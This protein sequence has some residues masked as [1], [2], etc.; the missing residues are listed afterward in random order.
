MFEI[1]RVLNSPKE[2]SEVL[3]NIMNLVRPMV[4]FDQCC[5]WEAEPSNNTI[6]R[7]IAN[8]PESQKPPTFTVGDG[9]LRGQAYLSRT[10]LHIP[11]L[12]LASRRS[13]VEPES[14][15]IVIIPLIFENEVV[16]LI[17]FY[18]AYPNYYD[19]RNLPT[20]QAIADEIAISVAKDRLFREVQ[21][22]AVT[23]KLTGLHNRLYFEDRIA[24]DINR[25]QRYGH[26]VSLLFIDID[27]FKICNDTYGHAAGDS[28]LRELSSVLRSSV[29]RTDLVARYG[30]EEFVMILPNTAKEQ[31]GILAEKIRQVVSTYEFTHESIKITI[32]VSIGVASYP[33][34][35]ND[36]VGL[37][38]KADYAMYQA[39]KLG[40][41]RV[42]HS[43]ASNNVMIS[44]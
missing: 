19:K 28:V 9:G 13:A 29:R 15:S 2:F 39:K 7:L 18:K 40:R 12:K 31:A 17:D 27:H 16:G 32:T 43:N 20:M 34:D 24:Y 8:Y 25:G 44:P 14:G 30:G 38:K 22:S 4:S 26:M 41:N 3:R 42:S 6:S 10:L 35:S 21:R 5:I 1:I 11:D 36:P 33:E 37:V 23:D